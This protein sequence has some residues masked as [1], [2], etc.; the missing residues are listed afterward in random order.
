MYVQPSGTILFQEVCP[1]KQ[2]LHYLINGKWKTH[3]VAK[4]ES[5][6][7]YLLEN[8]I[9][10]KKSEDANYILDLKTKKR[11]I[12]DTVPEHIEFSSQLSDN[13]M[14]FS[15]NFEGGKYMWIDA[16]GN[17]K[18]ENADLYG[19]LNKGK[20]A[21]IRI[22]ADQGYVLCSVITVV[23]EMNDTQRFYHLEYPVQYLTPA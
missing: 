9:L 19:K 2:V 5:V 7:G 21:S 23:D 14:Y 17:L 13:L 3:T 1:D 18:I 20:E 8:V 16:K 22:E 15:G 10:Y 11:K 4:D 6:R 12:I